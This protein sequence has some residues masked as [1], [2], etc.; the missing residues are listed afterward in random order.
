MLSRSEVAAAISGLWLLAPLHPAFA[1][2]IKGQLLQPAQPAPVR[3]APPSGFLRRPGEKVGETAVGTDYYIL[4][5]LDV[6]SGLG[7]SQTWVQVAPVDPATGEVDPNDAGWVYYGET[8]A[9]RSLNFTPGASTTLAPDT[10][11][12]IILRP[13]EPE[14]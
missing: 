9:T 5:Q 12:T 1:D 13:K 2:D 11:P 6:Q 3:T 10:Q 14:N 4:D 7:A 8:A